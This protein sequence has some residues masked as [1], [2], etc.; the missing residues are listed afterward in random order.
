MTLLR[1]VPSRLLVWPDENHWI[2][3][4]ENSRHFYQEVWDWLARWL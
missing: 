1:R 4:A 3:N 2:L